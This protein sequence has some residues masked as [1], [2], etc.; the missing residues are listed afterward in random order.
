MTSKTIDSKAP[1]SKTSA[2]CADVSA[3]SPSLTRKDIEGVSLFAFDTNQ[4][5]PENTLPFNSEIYALEGE[6][7]ITIDGHQQ[8]IKAGET[9]NIPA[10]RTHSL[11]AK[12]PFS[13]MLVKLCDG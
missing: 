4:G 6:A 5:L 13:M 9:L 2:D 1:A 12:K 10:N 11:Q 3:I 7:D 8:H